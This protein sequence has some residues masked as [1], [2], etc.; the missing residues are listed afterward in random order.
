M[1]P[2]KRI[3]FD[4]W[5]EANHNKPFLLEEQLA[6]YC[7]NDVEILLAALITFRKDFMDI[8][9]GLDVLREAMTIASACIKHFRL[10]H[11]KPNHLGIVPEKGYDNVD[12]QSMLALKFLNWYS[13]KHNVIVR[14]AHSKDGEKRI[15]NYRLDGWIEEEKLGIEINGCCW[16]GCR[17]CYKDKNMLLPNGKTVENQRELDKK[18]YR[19]EKNV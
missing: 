3:Q 18:R 12:N 19:N 7:V 13:E 1:M 5:F 14:T 2:E 17:K 9:N 6:A 8:S 10:N 4:K 15:E 16:H 11:L